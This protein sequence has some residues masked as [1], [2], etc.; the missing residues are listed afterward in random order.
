M[1]I[2]PRRRPVFAL[3]VWGVNIFTRIMVVFNIRHTPSTMR[4][5][6][7]IGG[8]VYLYSEVNA[9]EGMNLLSFLPHFRDFPA[10]TRA[11]C[12]AEEVRSMNMGR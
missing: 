3:V 1:V 10:A 8:A 11:L 12:V 5:K 7:P 6:F 2:I 9:G 4:R